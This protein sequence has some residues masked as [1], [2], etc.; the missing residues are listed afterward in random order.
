MLEALRTLNP[1]SVPVNFYHHNPA[2]P[3]K[4]NP[5]DA[6]EALG[7]IALAREMLPGAERIMV[8]GGRE[9][10]FGDR[11]GEIFEAGANSIVIGDYLTT[12]GRDRGSDLQMLRDLGLAVADR[13]GA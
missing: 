12:R 4:P 8:A 7:L 3:L 2:L 6:D 10:M 13:V 1:V 9:L 11:Q 5:L